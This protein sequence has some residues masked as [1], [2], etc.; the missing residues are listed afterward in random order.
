MRQS[1]HFIL[2]SD[3]YRKNVKQMPQICNYPTFWIYKTFL[4]SIALILLLCVSGNSFAQS[5]NEVGL[6]LIKSF[7][8][9]DFFASG[10]NWDMAQDNRGIMYFGNTTGIL[11]YD[12]STWRSIPFTSIVRSLSSSEDGIIYVGAQGDFGYLLPDST[13]TNQFVSLLPHVAEK[14]REFTNVWK[15]YPTNKGVYFN[16]LSHLFRW[17]NDIDPALIFEH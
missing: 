3:I 15:T 9:D 1:F 2:L 4:L 6:P 8:T 7:T 12:G 11:E 10:Q 16:A 14:D 13:G 5:E 17:H